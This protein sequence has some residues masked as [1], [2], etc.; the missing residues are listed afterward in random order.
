MLLISDLDIV[1]PAE[2]ER[3]REIAKDVASSWGWP[4]YVA[5]DYVLLDV[6]RRASRKSG[7]LFIAND[8]SCRLYEEGRAKVA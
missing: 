8:V 5:L 7:V 6:D 4:Y 2:A 3:I 1:A